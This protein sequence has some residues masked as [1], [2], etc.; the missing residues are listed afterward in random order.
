MI[1]DIIIIG[2]GI[3]GL[4]AG[5]Y[6]S[7][8]Y[9][10][11]ILD[12]R[13]YLG[14][15]IQTYYFDKNI[16]VEC[17]AGRLNL[18]HKLL[19]NLIKYL[20]LNLIKLNPETDYINIKNNICIKNIN[21]EFFKFIRYII[22]NYNKYFS[23]NELKK[24][25]FAQLCYFFFGNKTN[26]IKSFFGYSSEFDVLNAFDAIRV[27]TKDFLNNHFYTIKEGFHQLIIRLEQKCKAEI[28]LNSRV[29]DVK[30]IN[31]IFYVETVNQIIY[32]SKKIIFAIKASQLKNFYILNTIHFLL[33]SVIA[34]PLL[35]IYAKYPKI[36]NKFWFENIN[37]TVTDSIL[38]FIIPIDKN[39]GII[40]ISYTDGSDV[41]QFLKNDELISE[42][43]ILNIIEKELKL[44]F[45]INVPKP[46]KIKTC[47]W[48]EGCHYWKPKYDSEIISS[49]IINPIP[50]IYICGEAYSLN[51]CWIEGALE[52]SK[53]VVKLLL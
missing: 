22:N 26:L 5:Y 3:S 33:N 27:F 28:K 24:M 2:G 41:N 34:K 17:G 21:I 11:L 14:G 50:N 9:K 39:N 37:N 52:T 49:L 31:D 45:N 18:N 36:N 7:K 1:Y 30:N 23:N 48:K 44:I 47:Y 20:N 40:M 43:D 32:R 38:K 6:L 10:V 29:I 42:K 53:K 13:N 35:R 16:H 51:Q 46:I 15:R 8:K 19:L 25:T 4:S 12:D